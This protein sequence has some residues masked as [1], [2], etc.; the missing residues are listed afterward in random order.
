M[1]EIGDMRE[2]RR[3]EELLRETRAGTSVWKQILGIAGEN[4]AAAYLEKRG[5]QICCRNYR[6]RFGEIDIIAR[7]P[8]EDILC[9][10]EVKT[11][12][13]LQK[14]RPCE[15]VTPAKVEHLRR[16]AQHYL[17][18]YQPVCGRVRIDAAEILYIDHRFYIRYLENITE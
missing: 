9:F 15:A 10:V 4:R 7:Q 1:G 12:S 14:G 2:D 11:R 18:K 3:A 8:Q 6:C 16:T 13:G 17:S 5:F